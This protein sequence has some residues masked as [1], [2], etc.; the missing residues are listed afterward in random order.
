MRRPLASGRPASDNLC[1]AGPGS[2]TAETMVSNTIQ[3]GFESHPGRACPSCRRPP[4]GSASMYTQETAWPGSRPTGAGRLPPC[5]QAWRPESAGIALRRVA[6]PWRRPQG[7]S[8][9]LGVRRIWTTRSGGDTPACSGTIPGRRLPLPQPLRVTPWRVSCDQAYPGIVEDV[10]RAHRVGPGGGARVQRVPGTRGRGGA[11]LLEALAV[12][13]PAARARAQAR[14]G[15]GHDGLAVGGRR[16]APGRLP[17]RP[18]PLRR[19][20]GEQLG[21]APGGGRAQDLPL[22]PWQ[23]TNVSEEILGWCGDALDLVDVPW[24]RSNA[25]TLSV[26]TRAGVARLDELVGPKS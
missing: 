24:R 15:A 11:E 26:S 12:P 22:P 1:L 14:A 16:G 25:K 6:G 10:A 18:V 9:V 8:G 7:G 20:P 4:A 3:C 13:V 23:F 21:S 19:V 5:R 2:P 17:S